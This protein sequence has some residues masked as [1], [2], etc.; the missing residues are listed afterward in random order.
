MLLTG[1]LK[2]WEKP[3][4]ERNLYYGKLNTKTEKTHIP[5]DITHNWIKSY[6]K[7][8]LSLDVLDT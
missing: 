1:I 6:P 8:T 7:L 4:L 5:S 2:L 3:A